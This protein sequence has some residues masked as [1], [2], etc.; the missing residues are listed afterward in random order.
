VAANTILPTALKATQLK[1]DVHPEWCPGCGD[2]GIIN[3]MQQAIAEARIAPWEVLFVSGVGCSGKAP[4]YVQTYGVHTLHGRALPFALGS[5][6]ANP[7]LKVIVAGGDG[8]GY[9]IGAGHFVH[10]GRR[11]IDAT[12]MVWNNEVYGLTKGQAS[13]TLAKGA[14]PKSLA[15]PNINQAINP[16]ALAIA[17]G[18]TYVARSYAFD[19]KHLKK[20]IIDAMAHRGMALIDVLQPCPTYND[21]HTK[22]YFSGKVA[23]EDGIEYPRTYYLEDAGYNGVVSNPTD[24]EEVSTKRLAAIQRAYQQEERVPL[25]VYWK[26][27]LPTYEDGLKDNLP[28]MR[29]YTPFNVPFHDDNNVPTTNLHPGMS[30]YII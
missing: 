26:I 2:F 24:E 11:N 4:H 3:A 16:L 10:A 9:G 17:C 1:S 15:L 12:Y 29:E 22:E 7:D 21:I 23:L 28:L 27:D 19:A 5:K 6:L 14:Q 25:G 20:T 18:Y 8:D 13:P 30:S